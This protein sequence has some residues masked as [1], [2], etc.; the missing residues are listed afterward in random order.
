MAPAM[1]QMLVEVVKVEDGG[2]GSS[3]RWKQWGGGGDEVSSGGKL[4]VTVETPVI[5]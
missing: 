3:N 4:S 1:V 2:K 5:I